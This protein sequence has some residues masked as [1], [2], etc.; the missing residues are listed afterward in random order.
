MRPS[1]RLF[2]VLI[3]EALMAAGAAPAAAQTPK[4][5]GIFHV[6]AP[7]PPSLDPHQIAGFSTHLYASP[8]YGH[9]VRFPAG[10]GVANL[11]EIFRSVKGLAQEEAEAQ[12]AGK[13]Y[14]ALKTAVADALVEALAPIQERY[15]AIRSDDGALM[16]QLRTAA[17][18]LQPIARTTLERV[19]RA[20]G[21]R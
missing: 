19:Q 9:L 5:G 6:P 1:R 13:P 21:L 8:V 15:R 14:S 7:E 12:F 17:E 11:I 3:V 2:T 10:P 20:V 4:R 16:S 18:R